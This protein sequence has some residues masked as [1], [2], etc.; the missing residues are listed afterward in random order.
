MK[1]MIPCCDLCEA[2]ALACGRSAVV[3]KAGIRQAILRE[4]VTVQLNYGVPT[5][6]EPLLSCPLSPCCLIYLSPDQ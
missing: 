6:V 1:V 4:E 5:A 3:G 2:F